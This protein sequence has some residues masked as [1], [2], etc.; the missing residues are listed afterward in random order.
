MRWNESSNG[1][2]KIPEDEC[3]KSEVGNRL[4]WIYEVD[5][6][7]QTQFEVDLQCDYKTMDYR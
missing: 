5:L 6:H 4:K 2:E 7:L 1:K 3:L